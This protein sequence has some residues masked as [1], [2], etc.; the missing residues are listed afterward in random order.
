MAIKRGGMDLERDKR[1]PNRAKKAGGDLV[2][3]G[4]N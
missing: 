4:G 3:V 2:G 1:S